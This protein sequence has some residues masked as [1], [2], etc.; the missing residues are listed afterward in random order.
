VPGFLGGHPLAHQTTQTAQAGLPF[1]PPT[2][3]A[4]L[5][6]LAHKPFAQ[7]GSGILRRD[8]TVIFT[9]D[10]TLDWESALQRPSRSVTFDL[11]NFLSDISAR[12]KGEDGLGRGPHPRPV[13]SSAA[14]D[15]DPDTSLAEEW[16]TQELQRTATQLSMAD[17]A[18]TNEA[19]ITSSEDHS[20]PDS[21]LF[22]HPLPASGVWTQEPRYA[23]TNDSVSHAPHN[24]DKDR[25]LT[26][27]SLGKSK[28][29]YGWDRPL[30][31]DLDY[32][33]H[34]EE[35]SGEEG[36]YDHLSDIGE[37]W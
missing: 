31:P 32:A 25:K 15:L 21:M 27:V 9:E 29:S 10:E 3:A 7:P 30:T 11:P 28:G 17:D 19:R 13:F 36:V 20:L 35:F 26:I 5:T 4:S 1:T 22:G 8:S 37:H 23:D 24:T 6:G 33:P 12:Q 34:H 2:P 16:A 18:R 14:Y